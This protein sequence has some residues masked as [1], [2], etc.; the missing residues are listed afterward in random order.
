[1]A[2]L[3]SGSIEGPAVTKQAERDYARTVKQAGLY[4]KPYGDPRVFREFTLA[5]DILNQRVKRGRVLDLGCGPGWT[6]L[7]LARAGYEVVGADI[8][9]RMI[10]IAQER[11]QQEN[12][13]ASFVVADAEELDLEEREFDAAVFFDSLHH[14]PNYPQALRRVAE[15]LCV[16]G[17]LLLMEPTWLHLYSPH[18]REETA[19]YGVTEI[20]FT[21]WGLHRELRRAGFSRVEHWYDPGPAAL[22]LGGFLKASVRLWCSFLIGFPQVK[23]VVLAR[24]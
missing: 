10:E 1:M 8:A 13:K 4:R 15:H 18:A 12:S 24:K 22:G 20:G 11:A 7:L 6:S 23:H 2:T 17:Y 5:L 21:R 16:G 3:R 19:K 14:C 9:E